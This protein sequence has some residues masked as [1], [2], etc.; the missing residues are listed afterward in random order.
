MTA[1]DS[2]GRRLVRKAQYPRRY[3]QALCRDWV[4]QAACRALPPAEA[5]RIFFP[6]QWGGGRDRNRRAAVAEARQICGG[7]P[8]RRECAEYAIRA[9]VSDGIWAGLAATEL[10]N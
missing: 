5:D 3:H 7:C 8:V 1:V 4:L 9:C 6:N 2:L 10:R